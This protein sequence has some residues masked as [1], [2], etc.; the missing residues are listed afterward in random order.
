MRSAK[1]KI[2]SASA[3]KKALPSRKRVVFTN[4]CFDLIH[5]GH[6]AYL[7]QARKQGD[8]LV[9][10]LNSDE[11][12][13]RLKGPSRPVNTLADRLVVMASLECVDY[14]TWFEQDTPLE[15]IRK[16]GSKI[17]VLVKGGDWKPSQ[18]VGGTEVLGWGGKVRSLRFV[19]GKST[20]GILKKIKQPQR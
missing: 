6:V 12:V 2:R 1:S 3:L 7:E 4:G 11:S 20:T 13:A 5:P 15:V 8:L 17:R 16:I 10:A 14:V 9:V 19:E 18:I